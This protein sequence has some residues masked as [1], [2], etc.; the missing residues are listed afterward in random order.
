MSALNLADSALR[1]PKTSSGL[2]IATL[3]HRVETAGAVRSSPTRDTLGPQEKALT[4]IKTVADEIDDVL[5]KVA[6][7]IGTLWIA[8]LGFLVTFV[9]EASAEAVA[10]G[11]GV[12]TIAAL[13]ANLASWTKVIA[14]ISIA[15]GVLWTFFSGAA[16]TGFKDLRQRLN[17]NVPFPGGRWPKA[18]GEYTSDGSITDGDTTAW[19]LAP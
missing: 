14:G 11:T 3:D 13:V 10:A 18:T 7:A 9:V 19:R 5:A 8:I 1:V 15:V 16:L 4:W 12:G 17:D 2:V 6:I